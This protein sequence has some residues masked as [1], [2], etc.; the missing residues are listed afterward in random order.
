MKNINM[1]KMLNKIF[2]CSIAIIVI[3]LFNT[4]L[5]INRDSSSSS[6]NNSNS[7]E[8]NIEEVN[9]DYDVS[10]FT[11][12][13]G[14]DL[15]NKTKGE[16][17]VVYIGRSTCEWCVKFVPILTETTNK[18]KLNTLYI[19]IAKI[20]DFSAGG[21]KDQESYDFLTKMETVSEFENYMSENFGA[22]PMLLIVKD[23]KLIDAQTGYT[24]SDAL[25]SFL[26]KNG[27]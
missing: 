1:Q 20:I 15:K 23:G 22:T 14:S 4:I 12:I 6:Q 13:N 24:E 17:T 3:L 16:N 8:K 5:I 9:G 11:E 2:A 25:N 26:E 19:D 10:A 21:I 7:D 27:F 18:Y